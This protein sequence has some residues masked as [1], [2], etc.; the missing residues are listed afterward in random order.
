MAERNSEG[1]A[2]WIVVLLAIV[3]G[4]GVVADKLLASGLLSQWP[5]VAAIV[6]V[7]VAAATATGLYAG[8]RPGKTVAMAQ[9]EALRAGI[10]AKSDGPPEGPLG[11]V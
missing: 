1:K 9:A 7:L 5:T 10:A 6:G 8:S 3:A 4:L 2:T 11:N